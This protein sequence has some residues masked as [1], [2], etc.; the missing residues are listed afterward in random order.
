[1]AQ[2]GWFKALSFWEEHVPPGF[3]FIG[4]LCTLVHTVLRDCPPRAV[5]SFYHPASLGLIACI[6]QKDDPCCIPRHAICCDLFPLLY[7]M[8]LEQALFCFTLLVYWE[9]WDSC[10][11]LRTPMVI[12]YNSFSLSFP[13]WLLCQS[14]SQQKY[15]TTQNAAKQNS[16]SVRGEHLFVNGPPPH[17]H[18]CDPRDPSSHNRQPR[19]LRN[20]GSNSEVPL[21]GPQSSWTLFSQPLQRVLN[22]LN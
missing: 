11:S 5:N 15:K 6:F 13:P 19:A 14:I 8:R 12:F 3:H 18:T 7:H 1:M 9:A 17:T 16:F 20:V 10:R 22:P 21:L 4:F 2:S